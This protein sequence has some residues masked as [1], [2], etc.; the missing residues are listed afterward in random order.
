MS[1]SSFRIFFWLKLCMNLFCVAVSVPNK[2]INSTYFCCSRSKCQYMHAITILLHLNS[3]SHAFVSL[4]RRMFNSFSF[5][6]FFFFLL[7]QERFVWLA[8]GSLMFTASH[9]RIKKKEKFFRIT[10]N[11]H[12]QLRCDYNRKIVANRRNEQKKLFGI[13][14]CESKINQPY[15]RHN[16]SIFFLWFFFV[17]VVFCVH[18]VFRC[19]LN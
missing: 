17:Y 5:F 1:N 12:Q 14:I 6:R 7:F 11:S 8:R 16:E 9:R 10:W 15:K 13:R 3:I 18:F 19:L 2:W 4:L